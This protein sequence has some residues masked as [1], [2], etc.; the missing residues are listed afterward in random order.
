[1]NP[2]VT[3]SDGIPQPFDA[4]QLFELDR[5]HKLEVV[6]NEKRQELLDTEKELEHVRQELRN[7]N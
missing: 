2:A 5:S 7:L 1:M 6:L 3:G 4:A